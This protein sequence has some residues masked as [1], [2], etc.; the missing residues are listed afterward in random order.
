MSKMT[1]EELSDRMWTAL[2]PSAFAFVGLTSEPQGDVPMTVHVDHDNRKSLW[3]FTV[4]QSRLVASGPATARFISSHIDLFSRLN[5]TIA[6]E[7]DKNVI[8][9]LWNRQI[10]AWY[11]GG[12]DDPDLAVVRFDVDQAEIWTSDMSPLTAIKLLVGAKVQDEFESNHA[13][14][15]TPQ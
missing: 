2:A 5:G 9:R 7:T 3:I 8:D 14:V 15:A 1:H 11:D 13:T 10:A 6:I 4:Q 12:R